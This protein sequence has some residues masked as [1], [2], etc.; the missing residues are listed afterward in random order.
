M[1]FQFV[2]WSNAEQFFSGTEIDSW[3]IAGKSLKLYGLK[4]NFTLDLS[5]K[6]V[7]VCKNTKL[8]RGL[9]ISK[10]VDGK[11]IGDDGWYD[12]RLG[13]TDD[14]AINVLF[15]F[16]RT[17]EEKVH[18]PEANTPSLP[19]STSSSPHSRS[20]PSQPLNATYRDAMS[21][22]PW[23]LEKLLSNDFE[24]DKFLKDHGT[25]ADKFFHMIVLNAIKMLPDT[26]LTIRDGFALAG[27]NNGRKK[28]Y[29]ADWENFSTSVDKILKKDGVLQ[30]LGIKNGTIFFYQVEHGC[31]RHD[32]DDTF[33]YL[34]G[35]FAC[36]R[37]DV[38]SRREDCIEQIVE[39]NDD[40]FSRYLS[41]FQVHVAF[42]IGTNQRD[43]YFHFLKKN[44]VRLVGRENVVRL[45]FYDKHAFNFNCC[46]FSGYSDIRDSTTG[47]ELREVMYVQSY[48]NLENTTR[49]STGISFFTYNLFS[50]FYYE[51]DT[52]L[53][54]STCRTARDA[55]A[56]GSSST[57]IGKSID[58][59]K[60][61]CD[62]N[63][64]RT[65][66]KKRMDVE[67]KFHDCTHFVEEL[68]KFHDARFEVVLNNP[69]YRN[70]L[71]LFDKYLRCWMKNGF[72]GSTSQDSSSSSDD[73]DRSSPKKLESCKILS[74]LFNS[75]TI[76]IIDKKVWLTLIK[77]TYDARFYKTISTSMNS[78]QRF[79]RYSS[80]KG[81]SF[82]L[83]SRQYLF[84]YFSCLF[85]VTLDGND[86]ARLYDAEIALTY[87][88]RGTRKFF[89]DTARLEHLKKY[90]AV[91]DKSPP[92]P[93]PPPVS[94][95]ES[96]RI[97]IYRAA[98]DSGEAAP[99][100]TQHNNPAV[101]PDQEMKN[102]TLVDK[103]R[104]VLRDVGACDLLWK[105][106]SSPP[107][108]K[109]D[110]DVNKKKFLY[111]NDQNL[112]SIFQELVW[113]NSVHRDKI[114]NFKSLLKKA[115]S[116][117]ENDSRD[118][119]IDDD[120]LDAV[121]NVIYEQIN[122][123]MTLMSRYCA[124][125]QGLEQEYLDPTAVDPIDIFSERV[126]KRAVNGTENGSLKLLG[127][128]KLNCETV[129][130]CL[131]RNPSF[132]YPVIAARACG[133]PQK[134]RSDWF[135][136]EY[137]ERLAKFLETRC[138]VVPKRFVTPTNNNHR[139]WKYLG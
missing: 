30:L 111:D 68:K 82:P 102:Q 130:T 65:L 106:L 18:Q 125:W 8:I 42:N 75:R 132:I 79:L 13:S 26:S 50:G 93:P 87:F 56:V 107:R 84:E 22:V 73:D 67:N 90:K 47:N 45:Q 113:F 37:N 109:E 27:L 128:K 89:P 58:I 57:V 29:I 39:K 16:R 12:F 131:L 17:E 3:C 120:I 81:P 88:M 61:E 66:N 10:D 35:K 25:V 121:D 86:L 136:R 138:Q 51:N 11:N 62:K 80:H 33:F 94:I 64:Y 44:V 21:D 19:P 133:I 116:M 28:I 53:K 36:V 127:G 71:Y 124:K 78:V 76:C 83:F 77:S 60:M 139:H 52:F 6:D 55:P 119:I 115:L 117:M 31:K 103:F 7:N 2:D 105:N 129:A 135:F 14:D 63:F 118:P 38:R 72:T 114:H 54:T 101:A 20:G 32:I 122:M 97:V 112:K 95:V 70:P 100:A 23:N 98:Q 99:V 108:G 46:H 91:N 85:D 49:R 137:I 104:L 34:F 134:E 41:V 9:K 4:K 59:D 24:K 40:F 92:P 123:F 5:G 126:V 15:Q 43:K 48:S 69:S 74:A 110:F 96:K 1:H